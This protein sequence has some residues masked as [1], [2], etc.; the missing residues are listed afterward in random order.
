MV[1]N[2]EVPEGKVGVFGVDDVVFSVCQSCRGE[3]VAVT[4]GAAITG[5]AAS[6]R[7]G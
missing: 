1:T 5:V 7:G 3:A 6:W 4:D 2:L